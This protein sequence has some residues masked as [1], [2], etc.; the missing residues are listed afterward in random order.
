MVWPELL[1]EFA[2]QECLAGEG[3]GALVVGEKVDQFVAEDGDAA[4][5]ETDDGD[6]GF[7]LGGEFVQDL[8]EQAFGAVEHADVVERASAA[9]VGPGD[10][11]AEAGGFE[12]F[13]GGDGG[14]GEE[15]VV[16]GVRPRGGRR[17]RSLG[18]AVAGLRR[19]RSPA[20]TDAE[21][22]SVASTWRCLARRNHCLKV[23]GSEGRDDALLG[24]IPATSLARS[25]RTG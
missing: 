8:E 5:L 4:G 12:D 14:G 22:D 18:L 6:S 17:E 11:D 21:C 13:D 23:C 1:E 20:A 3:L 7:D 15:V 2:E 25:R 19:L 24:E 16:E 10:E 9:E